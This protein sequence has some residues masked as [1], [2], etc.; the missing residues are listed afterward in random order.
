[1]KK[2]NFMTGWI[3]IVLTFSLALP[4]TVSGQ[5]SKSLSF[6]A[7]GFER[8]NQKKGG[9]N[10]EKI[11]CKEANH[12]RIVGKPDL[13]VY[14]KTFYVP[15]GQVVTAVNFKSRKQQEVQLTDDLIPSQHRV[16]IRFAGVDTLFVKSSTSA[17]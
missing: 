5:I 4:F 17:K 9:R 7:T 6:D 2:P 15:K 3:V 13:P 12:S 16:P 1:M 8:Q 14:Y 11:K 10:Y